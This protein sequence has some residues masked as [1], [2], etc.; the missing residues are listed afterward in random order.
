MKRLLTGFLVTVV[1]MAIA[2]PAATELP[3]VIDESKIIWTG[4]KVIGFHQGTVQLKEGK[5]RIHG[6][7]LQGGYFVIDLKTITCTDIPDSDPVPKKKL[8][9]HLKGVDFFDVARY[10]TARFEIKEIHP[11]PDNPSRYL[12]VGEL[13]IKG[14]TKRLKIEIEPSTQTDKLFIAQADI[15]FNRQH[16]GVSYTGLKDELVHD[17]VKLNVIIKARGK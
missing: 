16:W 5:V 10:P 12:S 3:V 6:Q 15:R 1:N 4:T 11:H 9:A 7:Q 2:Q 8:E 13:T 14:I 17:D